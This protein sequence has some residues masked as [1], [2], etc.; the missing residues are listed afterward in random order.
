MRQLLKTLETFIRK[1]AKCPLVKTAI[2]I[3]GMIGLS[4]ALASLGPVGAIIKFL[5]VLAGIYFRGKYLVNAIFDIV[6]NVRKLLKGNG[7]CRLTCKKKIVEKI[8]GIVGVIVEAFVVSGVAKDTRHTMK[9]LKQ[10]KVTA[11]HSHPHTFIDKVQH[12]AHKAKWH[13]IHFGEVAAHGPAGAM[14][15]SESLAKGAA[16][17]ADGAHAL[18]HGED[19]DDHNDDDHNDDDHNDDDH[20]DDDHKDDDH[21]DDNH[22][23]SRKRQGSNDDHRMMIM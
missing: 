18:G 15:H 16:M 23:V 19:H 5:G 9:D 20:N 12:V 6:E 10:L 1:A 14:L 13:D 3:L 7:S 8:F 2:F 21:N 4:F 22:V 17:I 11:A